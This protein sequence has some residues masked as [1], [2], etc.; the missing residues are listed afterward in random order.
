M[1]KLTEAQIIRLMR[2]E[3]KQRLIETIDESDMFDDKGNHL[4]SPGLKVKHKDT[5][6][7]YTVDSVE[8]EKDSGNVKVTLKLPDEPRFDPPEEPSE[9]ISDDLSSPVLGESG[10]DIDA[11]SDYSMSGNADDERVTISV[12]PGAST[13]DETEFIIDQEE[14]EKEYE[15]T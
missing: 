11:P 7:E 14:F 15:V 6:F 4:L 1:S 2:Q 13:E 12:N 8:G 5:K 3:Y 9:V 10:I